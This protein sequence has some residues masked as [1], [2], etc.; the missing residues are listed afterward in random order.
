VDP[1]ANREQVLVWGGITT[2]VAGLVIGVGCTLLSI[3]RAGY[4]VPSTASFGT[5]GL[6]RNHVLWAYISAGVGVV[7]G[8]VGFV[9]VVKGLSRMFPRAG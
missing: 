8:T 1:R 7:V 5:A 4:A 2:M 3:W 6:F 9:L